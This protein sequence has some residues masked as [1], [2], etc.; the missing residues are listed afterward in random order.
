[1]PELG[2]DVRGNAGKGCGRK[3]GVMRGYG[4]EIRAAAGGVS[5]YSPYRARLL[6]VI[7]ALALAGCAQGYETQTQGGERV[8]E[9]YLPLG[10]GRIEALAI[11]P[12]GDGPRPALLLIHAG[13]SR[14]QRFR[15][16]MF[17]LAGMGF[18]AMSISLPGFGDSTGPED[19][20]GP[21]SVKAVL[22]AAKYLA[23][24]KDV[25]QGGVGIYGIGQGATAALLAAIHTRNIHL[26][27]LENG[28][29][30]LDKAYP[31][32]PPAL[33]ERLRSLLGGNPR[34][35]PGAYRLRSPILEAGKLRGPVLIIH[36]K[37]SRKFPISEA[38]GL[39]G[40]LE[41]MGLPHRFVTTRG[42]LREFR[43]SHPSIR[44]WVVPFM[45]KHL[46]LK[47]PKG[48]RP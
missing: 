42:R 39:A 30:G 12:P 43:P 10:G 38:K 47:I 13:K 7:L 2:R 20:A 21:Q 8:K 24:R 4:E 29:Y 45:Q 27:A 35:K 22:E 25:R 37:D 23:S 19:F 15:Q 33:R 9:W 46:H 11:W 5:K 1:M 36:S 41:K 44:R 17:R 26:T 14:A 31:R 32:L 34:E 28:V 18:T 16:T 3:C 6:G 48:V 40:A